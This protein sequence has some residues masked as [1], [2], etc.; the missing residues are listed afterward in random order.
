[1]APRCLEATVPVVDG[2]TCEVELGREFRYF[3][4]WQLIGGCPKLQTLNTDLQV[5]G[6]AWRTYKDQNHLVQ[7]DFN[8]EL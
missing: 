7:V 5:Q 6:E 8:D 2:N 1:M 4:R 3:C